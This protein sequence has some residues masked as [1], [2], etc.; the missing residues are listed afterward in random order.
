VEA[1]ESPALLSAPALSPPWLTAVLGRPVHSVGVEPLEGGGVSGDLVRLRLHD[2][3]TLVAKRPAVDEAVRERQRALGMYAREAHFYRE[4]AP[5]LSVRTPRC[6]FASDDLLL[7]EDLAPAAAGTFSEG[8]SNERV[9]AVIDAFVAMH[10]EWHRSEELDGLNWLWR[11]SDEEA[12]RWQQNLEGRLP[13]FVDRHRDA[14][15][16]DDVQAAE[17]VTANLAAL[18][19]AAAALPVTLCH[20]DPGPPNLMFVER[21]AEPAFVDWQLASAR[22]GALDLAWLLVLGVPIAA[23]R[24]R[25][26][27]WLSRYRGRLGLDVETFGRAHA[28]GVTLAVRAPIWM[29]GAPD[30]ERTAHVDAY[31]AATIPR[32][33]A[34]FATEEGRHQWLT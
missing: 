34:A 1:A 8:L 24:Q 28:L 17:L 6:F 19:T 32:A 3:S 29:G 21:G 9:D 30:S 13:R 15:T 31:A 5:R 23:Y 12:R 22:N 7:I 11:V 33:F 16:D 14:L 2:G 27:V 25:R 20:G 18:M 26:N 10:G 4:L